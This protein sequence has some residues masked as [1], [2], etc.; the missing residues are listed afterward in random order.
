M[1]DHQGYHDLLDW[2]DSKDIVEPRHFFRRMRRSYGIA[3]IVY[4]DISLNPAGIQVQSL[5]HT[6]KPAVLEAIAGVDPSLLTPLLRTVFSTLRPLDWSSFRRSEPSSAALFALWATLG[7]ASQGLSFPLVSRTGRAALLSIN[8]AATPEAW[9]DFRRRY[10][11]EIHS[12]AVHFHAAIVEEELRAAG[13][14]VARAPTLTPRERETLA[15]SAAGKSYW[16]IATILG[17]SERTV[18][19]F[20]GNAR[21]KLNVVSNTQAVAEAVWLGLIE[22]A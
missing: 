8:V 17:I 15:W 12:L 3:N 21:R 16:E 5:H 19:F 13:T 6:L 18:R 1:K 22:H 20:M 9:R 14:M 11:H 4:A 7:L 2:L 10:E